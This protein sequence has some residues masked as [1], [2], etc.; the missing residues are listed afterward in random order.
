MRNRR[1]R[2]LIALSVA[3]S[4]LFAILSSATASAAANAGLIRPATSTSAAHAAIV[5]PD[6]QV[7][8]SY[9]TAVHVWS[10]P[11]C[12]GGIGSNSLSSVV[13]QICMGNNYGVVEVYNANNDTDVTF[14]SYSPGSWYP[15][16]TAEWGPGIYLIYIDITGYSGS[17][18]CS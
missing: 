6:G 12:F 9:A 2:T 10:G 4:A 13:D 3:L 5:K 16:R 15:S 14:Y 18:T 7:S 8:C 17:D 11:I 1:V